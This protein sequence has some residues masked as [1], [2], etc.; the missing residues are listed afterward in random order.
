MCVYIHIY[1]CIIDVHTH[2]PTLTHTHTH[3][4]L[5]L[6]YDGFLLLALIFYQGHCNIYLKLANVFYDSVA[7]KN[8]KITPESERTFLPSHVLSGK[9]NTEI[10]LYLGGISIHLIIPTE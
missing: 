1:I 8:V 9:N 7:Y 5:P 2:T 10:I 6:S 4:H 3:T